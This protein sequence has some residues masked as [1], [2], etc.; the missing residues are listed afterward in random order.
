MP[1]RL[2][3]RLSDI[4]VYSGVCWHWTF[5]IFVLRSLLNHSHYIQVFFPW[6]LP[7][8][9]LKLSSS[10]GQRSLACEWR[11]RSGARCLFAKWGMEVKKNWKGHQQ[12]DRKLVFTFFAPSKLL[13]CAD[14]SIDQRKLGIEKRSKRD[15]RSQPNRPFL[16]VKSV[17]LI[18][19]YRIPESNNKVI[20]KTEIITRLRGCWFLSI[21]FS[22]RVN[23]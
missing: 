17:A 9:H 13:N 23:A 12:D 18:S 7:G 5:A 14:D 15:S 4:S 8:R 1:A 16:S 19:S 3:P 21:F 22:T 10:S 6:Q 11:R 2:C 20:R